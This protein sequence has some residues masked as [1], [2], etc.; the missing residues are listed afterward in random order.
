MDSLSAA[1]SHRALK[2]LNI[3]YSNIMFE[4]TSILS[5]IFRDLMCESA[6]PLMDLPGSGKLPLLIRPDHM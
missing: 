1:V 3:T 6:L 4:F 2:T 5:V